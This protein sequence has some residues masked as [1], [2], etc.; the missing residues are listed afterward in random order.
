MGR[1]RTSEASGGL[2]TDRQSL[3]GLTRL[4]REGPNDHEDYPDRRQAERDGD[5][6][7]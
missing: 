4:G 5:K 3:I 6:R 7:Q 1:A 2:V